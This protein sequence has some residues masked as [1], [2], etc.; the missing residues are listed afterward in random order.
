MIYE[1][2]RFMPAGDRYLL[3]EFGI[4]V[5]AT[6]LAAFVPTL[7]ATRV[8]P[9]EA[10]E[11]FAQG[12]FELSFPT[13]KHLEELRDL[14]HADAVLAEAAGR[15]VVPL[16]PKVV[17]TEDGFDVLLPGEPGFDEA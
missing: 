7:R 14:T 13:I 16:L 10:L 11:D 9:L 4:G 8:A 12:T 6:V 2:P 3:I 17:A 1:Q 5:V 15:P